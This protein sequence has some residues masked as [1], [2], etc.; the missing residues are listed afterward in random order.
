MFDQLLDL[1]KK[2]GDESIVK[3]P[4]IPNEKNEEVMNAASGSITNGLQEMFAQGNFKDIL[5]MFSGRSQG[6]ANIN[7]G[8]NSK[9]SGGFIQDLMSKFGLG[10]KEANK[11]A[12]DVIPNVTNEMVAKTNDPG[13]KSF[14]IQGIF[15]KLSGGS[16]SGFNMQSLLDKVK[17]GKFDIDGDGDTD[18]QD[19]IAL[20][21]GGGTGNVMDK[22]KGLFK[23]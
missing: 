23:G 22:V 6:D 13:D 1:V 16:T 3:N 11:V 4:A 15:N 12:D 20:V 21:K 8:L 5:N 9:L 14:D 19:L 17:G 18:F 10:Q 7:N 2:H